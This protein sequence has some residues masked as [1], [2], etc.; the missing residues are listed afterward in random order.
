M[1][2]YFYAFLTAA[3]MYC[4]IYIMQHLHHEPIISAADLTISARGGFCSC[5]LLLFNSSDLHHSAHQP[6][7]LLHQIIIHLAL[8]ARQDRK[9]QLCMYTK[10]V[11]K[12][13]FQNL[14]ISTD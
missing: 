12:V 3:M 13:K 6:A 1:Y 5:A 10:V 9:M 4:N 14:F 7:P 8:R 2:L 11:L